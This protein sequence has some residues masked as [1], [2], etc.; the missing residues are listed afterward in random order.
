MSEVETQHGQDG[1]E[2]LARVLAASTWDKHRTP[3]TRPCGHC[4]AAREQAKRILANPGPLLAALA[5]A[6][7]L[8]EDRASA[9]DDGFD[10]GHQAARAVNP[11]WPAMPTNPYRLTNDNELPEA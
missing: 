7:V 3:A 6:G 11:E 2:A 10:A 5:G 9:W 1:V 8:V 4:L